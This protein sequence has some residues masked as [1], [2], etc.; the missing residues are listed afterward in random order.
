[1]T[2]T[3]V[4]DTQTGKN[5]VFLPAIPADMKKGDLGQENVYFKHMQKGETSAKTGDAGISVKDKLMRVLGMQK[6][7]SNGKNTNKFSLFSDSGEVRRNNLLPKAAEVPKSPG[8]PVMREMSEENVGAVQTQNEIRMKA[9]PLDNNRLTQRLNELEMHVKE[10][11]SAFDNFVLHSDKFLNYEQFLDVQNEVKEKI[12]ILDKLEKSLE[13]SKNMIL[14]DAGYLDQI[15]EGFSHNKKKIE[16]LESRLNAM[17][18]EMSADNSLPPNNLLNMLLPSNSK[19]LSSTKAPDAGMIA[20]LKKELDAFKKNDESK[21]SD[22]QKLRESMSSFDGRMNKISI[23]LEASK[24]MIDDINRKITGSKDEKETSG[25][26]ALRMQI[27]GLTQ[28]LADV[29]KRLKIGNAAH[30]EAI[31]NKDIEEKID[32]E[33]KDIKT[34]LKPEIDAQI[35][36]LRQTVP[37]STGRKTADFL[38]KKDAERMNAEMS[39][40]RANIDRIKTAL[41]GL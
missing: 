31:N 38:P 21:Q 14:K 7:V 33:Y 17:S 40:V 34:G 6:D 41:N 37:E 11:H 25:I 10:I 35:N 8:E 13:E 12:Q 18:A 1:M 22:F 19:S 30:F 23:D 5:R 24:K 27:N 28:R 26:D 32:K 4:D 29:D 9:A 16:S 20:D 3:V 15:M 2:E 36:A 39:E